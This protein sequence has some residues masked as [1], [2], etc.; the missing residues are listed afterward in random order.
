MDW[1]TNIQKAIDYMEDNITEN[2]NYE[3]IAGQAH[4]SSFYFQRVFAILCNCTVGEYIRN[5][6]L[7][8]AGS[9]LVSTN[10]KIIE[11]A[12]KYGYETPESF[13]RAFTRFHEVT[14]SAARN[15]AA[16]LKSFPRLSLKSILEG[17][18][19]IM[20]NFNERGYVVKE[21]GPVYFTQDMDQ[22]VKW[23]KEILGWYGEIDERNADGAGV[24]GCV[25]NIPQEI[26]VLRIAPFTGIHMFYG[27]SPK[28]IIAFMM[29]QGID[30]LYEFVKSNGWDQITEVKKEAWGSKTCSV[31][32]IDG[33]ILRFFE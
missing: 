19:V 3:I 31:T 14:P 4:V 7:T 15:D 11:I 21:T 1:I 29:V 10:A 30:A 5:R 13:T 16:L 27:D 28:S 26:E 6:R 32:T 33:C 9:E 12:L 25:Y 18:N 24:Y 2:L 20:R 23:F 8:L 17:E 22:T